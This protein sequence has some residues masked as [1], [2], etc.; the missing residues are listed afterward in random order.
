[1]DLHL[2]YMYIATKGFPLKH[3]TVAVHTDKTSGQ[4]AVQPTI[5]HRCIVTSCII[6]FMT[7]I[8]TGF[9]QS[10]FELGYTEDTNAMKFSVLYCII[11]GIQHTRHVSDLTC[12]KFT[13]HLRRET[14]IH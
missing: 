12:F 6:I 3:V 11:S 1:M 5:E 10:A 4:W 8:R 13:E 14:I 7:N 2:Q 9:L